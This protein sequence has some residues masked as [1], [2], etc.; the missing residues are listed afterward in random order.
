MSVL[1]DK[2]ILCQFDMYYRCE[3][4]HSGDKTHLLVEM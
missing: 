4:V 1:V 2:N 3:H